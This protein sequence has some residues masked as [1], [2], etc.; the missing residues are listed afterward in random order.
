[1]APGP[2]NVVEEAKVWIDRLPA[3]LA[4]ESARHVKRVQGK[5]IGG[6]Q[7]FRESLQL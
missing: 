4:F 3:C 1:M 5:L 6:L 7:D 2:G